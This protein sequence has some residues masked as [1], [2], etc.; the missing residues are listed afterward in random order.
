MEGYLS[1]IVEKSNKW[2]AS[3]WGEEEAGVNGEHVS[4]VWFEW[5]F[6]IEFVE[7]AG[8]AMSARTGLR[9]AWAAVGI[10]GVWKKSPQA[11]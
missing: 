8:I 3:C 2:G 1:E 9:V 7:G 4:C 6:S 10:K 5:W 11:W